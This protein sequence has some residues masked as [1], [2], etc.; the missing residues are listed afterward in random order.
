MKS[1]DFAVD[2][3]KMNACCLLGHLKN[4]LFCVVFFFNQK[5]L[6]GCCLYW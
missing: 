4:Y 5:R 3:E 1:C 2:A 6:P